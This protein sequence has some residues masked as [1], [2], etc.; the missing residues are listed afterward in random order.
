VAEVAQATGLDKIYTDTTHPVPFYY[1]LG[2]DNVVWYRKLAVNELQ[3][4]K[5][6]KR[7]IFVN[8]TYHRDP[9]SLRCLQRRH[10]V[11]LKVPQQTDP[12]IRRPGKLTI[13][14]VPADTR[15]APPKHRTPTKSKK[16]ARTTLSATGAAS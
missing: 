5:V 3:F 9:V 14:I 2:R 4:C 6:K 1:Y 13:Y 10:P 12:P 8:D 15:K 7:F 11:V 16:Q